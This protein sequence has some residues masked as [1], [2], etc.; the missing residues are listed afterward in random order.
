MNE[1]SERYTVIE[2]ANL[3]AV[4]VNVN[5][6]GTESLAVLLKGRTVPIF[7]HCDEATFEAYKAVFELKKEQ[8]DQYLENLNKKNQD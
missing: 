3:D 7:I 1:T 5:A 6:D 4:M 2:M 8:L